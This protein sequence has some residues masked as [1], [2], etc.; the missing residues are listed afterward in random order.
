MRN[1]FLKYNNA[2]LIVMYNCNLYEST[3]LQGIFQ[4]NIRDANILIWN[5][6]PLPLLNNNIPDDY[7]NNIEIIENIDNLS[8]AH[9]YNFFINRYTAERYIIL[10]HDSCFH[11]EYYQEAKLIGIDEVGVPIITNNDHHTSPIVDGKVH[12]V[13]GNL[14]DKINSKIQ[15]LGSGLVIGKKICDII[16]SK[17]GK[18]FDERFYL[19][20]VDTTFFLRFL[21]TSQIS[22]IKL[23]K[24]FEHSQSKFEEE[25]DTISKFRKLERS[26]DYGLTLRYYKTFIY[27]LYALSKLPLKN[28]ILKIKGQKRRICFTETLRAFIS[29]KH[30]RDLEDNK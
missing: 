6:G 11:N 13:L 19:Y 20:G 21:F 18:V 27:S 17:Y 30:Y 28:I 3:T 9:I 5:N 26:N 12:D 7:K 29:G 15:A 14:D 10:D 4:E 2:I 25:S 1:N 16:K 24:G 8:L 22:H 23:I